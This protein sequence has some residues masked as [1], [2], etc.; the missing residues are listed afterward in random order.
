MRNYF[1]NHIICQQTEI[2]ALQV[3]ISKDFMLLIME[4]F[5][6][7]GLLLG[8]RPFNNNIPETELR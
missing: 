7:V 8:I 5:F 6:D 1:R 2:P 3:F 4:F